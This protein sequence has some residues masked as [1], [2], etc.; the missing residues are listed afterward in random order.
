MTERCPLC[1][2]TELFVFVDRPRVPV[3]QNF[4]VVSM[5]AA[6]AVRRGD[7]RLACCRSCG[8]VTN[9]AFDE[10][11]LQYGEGYENDQTCSPAFER[12][13]DDLV[14]GLVAE[15]ARG[16]HVIEVG[17]GQGQFLRRLCE[18]GNN[19]GIGFDPSY[20]GPDDLEGGRVK[21]VR[22]FYGPGWP[23]SEVDVVV[24]RHVIEHVPA[25]MK[26]LRAICAGI[27]RSSVG[28]VLAFETPAL[29]WI[30]E[31]TVIQ[32]FF[33]EHCS[34]F[35]E[36]SLQ[37]AFERVGV[38][39]FHARRVF[40]GQYMW[41]TARRELTNTRDA[42]PAGAATV[43]EAAHRYQRN[44]SARVARLK[45]ALVRLSASSKVAVWGA[46]AKGVTF[47][48]IVDQEGAFV[49]CIIDVNPKKQGKFVPGTGHAIL[50]PGQVR[51]R[52]IKHIVVLNPNYADE[53]RMAVHLDDPSVSIHIE[54]EL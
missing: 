30:L 36:A 50:S 19:R 2:A 9:L 18:T 15:G 29:G 6:R 26:F 5:E 49:D 40:G 37:F 54:G 44:E 27:D 8:F 11:L 43:V 39:D 28:S 7:L 51:Q 41:A 1:E 33:Y 17:C 31:G 45:E 35:T 16:K 32:D 24:C 12:H 38:L 20:V 34:Y 25:P 4:P 14:A 52:G 23:A 10:R 47:L 42:M 46:G 3:H 21:F 22:D 13:M 53:I 48:N